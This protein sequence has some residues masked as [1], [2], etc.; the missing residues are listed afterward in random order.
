[1]GRAA[2]V[3]INSQKPS[4]GE[5]ADRLCAMIERHGTLIG[6]VDV[7]DGCE[8]EL[9]READ[10]IAVLGGDGTLLAA[11]RCFFG[12]DAPLLGINTGRVGFLAAFDAESLEERAPDLFGEGPLSTRTLRMI[13]AR[14]RGSGGDE[15][16][17]HALNEL[18]ITA[19]PPFRMIT[20]VISID[21]E[22]GPSVSGDG[23]ILSTPTGSTAYNV[24]AG[25][26]IVAPNVA[27]LTLTPIA[28]H[29]LSFRPIVLP[30]RARIEV[31][32]ATGNDEDGSGTTVVADGQIHRRVR[33]GDVIE[34]CGG[35][36]AVEFVTDPTVSYWR[37]L[38]SKMHWA[39]PPK[40]RENTVG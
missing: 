21:G 39:A 25:G 1:V 33:T 6:R 7:A 13:T 40:G 20:L 27:G 37:T 35:G 14:V 23:L 38:M 11:T 31:E 3:A 8:L 2:L 32:V 4:A 24:S 34:L 26:P 9:A 22:R 18:V 10:V 5:A 12:V 30:E 19:G 17:L 15:E 16:T 28:A 36:R 29:S